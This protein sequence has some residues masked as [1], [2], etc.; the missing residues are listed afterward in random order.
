MLAIG[1]RAHH[2]LVACATDYL[3][4]ALQVY[5]DLPRPYADREKVAGDKTARVLLREQLDVL[6]T[7]INEIVDSMNRADSERLIVH[8]RFLAE[9][10]GVPGLDVSRGSG[11]PA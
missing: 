6:A 3:P 2:V 5:L 9:K 10:F 8:G 1:P 7:E 4:T 11:D